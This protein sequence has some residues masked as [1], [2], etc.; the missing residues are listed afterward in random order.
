MSMSLLVASFN[1]DAGKLDADYLELS[2]EFNVNEFINDFIDKSFLTEF[3]V[4]QNNS[5]YIYT[6]V[7]PEKLLN[8]LTTISSDD[9]YLCENIEKS[10]RIENVKIKAQ[11]LVMLNQM[12]Q[13][14]AIY[15]KAISSSDSTIK[16]I[17][18]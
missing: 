2:K 14:C 11:D 3:K 5:V 12:Y 15:Y 4:Y 10:K 17:V 16:L 18:A 7:N 6:E 1:S 8:K 9:S 13:L